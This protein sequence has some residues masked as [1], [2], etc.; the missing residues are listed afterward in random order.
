M[1]FSVLIGAQ[2]EHLEQLLE[3]AE[4][5]E[6][7]GIDGIWYGQF[8]GYDAPTVALAA[9]ART[10]RLMSGV[11][12]VTARPRHPITVAAHAHTVSV[13]TGRRYRFAV[14]LSHRSTI[15][16]I[17]G[18]DYPS[19]ARYLREYLSVL[20][21]LLD[22][23]PVDFDGEYLHAHAQLAIPEARP[24]SFYTGSLGP[25]ALEATGEFAAGTITY[26]AGVRTI[27]EHVFPR[28]LAGAARSGRP[29]PEVIATVPVLATDDPDGEAQRLIDF[30]RFHASLPEYQQVIVRE[31]VSHAS[32]MAIV[33]GADA[34]RDGIARFRDAGV[35]EFGAALV[36]TLEEE[37]R[38]IAMLGEVAAEF[39]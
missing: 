22:L 6:A 37:L 27:E 12:V 24:M 39:R 29:R 3:V 20:G 31:G 2:G 5:C 23:E 34:M 21:P 36:G 16:G 18:L 15:E 7:A 28:L 35:A 4:A 11:S 38:T 14:G 10:D 17:Y 26:L 30:T 25:L 32:E 33:G 8:L 19:P 9:A 1:R 13:L